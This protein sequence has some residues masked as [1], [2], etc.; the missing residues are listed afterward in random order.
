LSS[1][2]TPNGGPIDEDD[3][4]AGDAAQAAAAISRQ[5]AYARP[6]GKPGF[7]ASSVR[8]WEA[9][10]H[11][12]Q[13]IRQP[14]FRGSGLLRLEAV[15]PSL[16]A[17]VSLTG[18]AVTWRASDAGAQA[19]QLDA[20]VVREATE[21]QQITSQLHAVVAHDRG[22]FTAYQEHILAWRSLQAEVHEVADSDPSL[23]SALTYE[24][25][26]RLA[27]ARTLRSQ[28]RALLPDFGDERGVVEYDERLALQTLIDGESR[29][30]ELDPTRTLALATARH[31]QTIQLVAV[32]IL[33]VGALFLLTVAQLGRGITRIWFGALG[34][35]SACIALIVFAVIQVGGA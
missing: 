19:A 33:L 28:F 6:Q 21:E 25:Q 30:R 7:R 17:A 31:S 15:I 14:S 11:M 4:R 32:V 29:L 20:Q 8:L 3:L 24:L 5:S 18:A 34:A 22:I 9:M 2:E 10:R 12:A 27:L 23:A 26:G 16:I 13:R 35:L 1:P